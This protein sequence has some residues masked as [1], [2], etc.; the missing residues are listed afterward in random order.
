MTLDPKYN[1]A[2]TN[3]DGIKKVNVEKFK[4]LKSKTCRKYKVFVQLSYAEILKPINIKISFDIL[5]KIPQDSNKFCDTCVIIDPKSP[6]VLKKSIKFFT[7]CKDEICEHDLSVTGTINNGRKQF[8]L[9]SQRTMSVE[10]K[11]E[12]T[13]EPAYM[14]QMKVEISSNST[15]FSHIPSSCSIDL[16][17]KNIM[18]CDINNRMP[19]KDQETVK[20]NFTVDATQF[21]GDTFIIIAEVTSVGQEKLP[22]DNKL[23]S[24]VSL[25]EISRV[26]VIG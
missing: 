5:A 20:L 12:N 13:G 23:V 7:G 21:V 9:G 3:E 14:T 6:K 11:I 1:R 10:Y 18:V 22:E 17:N 4:L 25:A 15:Q 8:I 19:I 2:S 24:E 26:D 16:I